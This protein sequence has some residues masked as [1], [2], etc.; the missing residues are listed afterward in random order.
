MAFLSRTSLFARRATVNTV[1][2]SV[3][4]TWRLVGIGSQPD[5][6]GAGMAFCRQQFQVP[7]EKQKHL[8]VRKDGWEWCRV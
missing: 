6:E 1:Y 2:L 8:R 5:F 7:R 3:A 4:N